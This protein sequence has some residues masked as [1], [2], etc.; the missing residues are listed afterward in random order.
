MAQKFAYKGLAWEQLEKLSLEDFAKL[1][2]SRQRRSLK[3]GL[4]HEQKRLLEHIRKD[5]KGFHRTR[6]RSMVI[7]PEMAGARVGIHA[8]KE[9]VTVDLK[10]EMVGHRLGEFSLTRKHVKHSAPGVGATKSSKFVEK[11]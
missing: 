11:K 5:P 9:Y 1:A 4:G 2:G 10:P 7:V 6:A 8:G 3:R